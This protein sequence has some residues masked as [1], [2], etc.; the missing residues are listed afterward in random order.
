[1]MW[2]ADDLPCLSKKWSSYGIAIFM[3]GAYV[4]EEYADIWDCHEMRKNEK[5]A[6][7]NA[8]NLRGQIGLARQLEQLA[9][10]QSG[11][12]AFHGATGI[13]RKITWRLLVKASR[14]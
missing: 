6:W 14:E 12:A 5:S 7:Q 11:C 9:E 4:E 1:M 13:E 8:R 10:W 2:K 3:L